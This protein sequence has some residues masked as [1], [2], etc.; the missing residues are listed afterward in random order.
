MMSQSLTYVHLQR[1]VRDSDRGSPEHAIRPSYEAAPSQHLRV[2]MIPCAGEHKSIT[3]CVES[4]KSRRLYDI[5]AAW[6]T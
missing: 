4:I 6:D 2:M 1:I 3:F 5:R